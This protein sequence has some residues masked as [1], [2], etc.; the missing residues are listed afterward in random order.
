MGTVIMEHARAVE[1]GAAE[2][3]AL[4]DMEETER[5]SYEEHFFDCLDCAAE[6]RAS[7]AFVEDARAVVSQ[8]EATRRSRWTAWTALSWPV[9]LGAAAV[10]VL[11][12]GGPAAWLAFHEVPRLEG[13]LA[14]AESLQAAPWHFL[15]VSRSDPPVVTVSGS[16]RAVGLTLSRSEAGSSA[17]YVCEVRDASGRVV[18]SSVVPGPARGG[19]LQLLLPVGRL[20][21]GSHVLAVAGVEAATAR[22]A[23]SD[24]TA[25][26]FTFE[27]R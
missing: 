21:P 19:E 8:G 9:P 6:V 15:S 2:R 25:Y 20:Q 18:L 26:P 27:R 3:Y 12:L 5:E 11:S 7:A 23:V 24:F 14:E 13:A 16:Q 4:G 22:P 10:L 1:T 17:F